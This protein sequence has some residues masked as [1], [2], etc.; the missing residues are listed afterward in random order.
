M[1]LHF[2]PF[3]SETLLLQGA[4]LSQNLWPSLFSFFFLGPPLSKREGVQTVMKLRRKKTRGLPK[5]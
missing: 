1:S 2:S 4:H 5:G 3:A